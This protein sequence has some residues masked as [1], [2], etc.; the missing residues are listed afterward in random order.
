MTKVPPCDA[1]PGYTG[2]E[3]PHQDCFQCWSLY[4]TYAPA[5]KDSNEQEK[6][7]GKTSYNR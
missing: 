1:H 6:G 4:V 7:P 3:Y 2:A 5:G